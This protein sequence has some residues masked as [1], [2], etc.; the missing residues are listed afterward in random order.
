M[1][2]VYL[3]P[4]SLQTLH[5]DTTPERR[6]LCVQKLPNGNLAAHITVTAELPIF[7]FQEPSELHNC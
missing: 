5:I 1:T 7:F 2:H 3:S 4:D 6:E